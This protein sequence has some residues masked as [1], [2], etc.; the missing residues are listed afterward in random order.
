MPR[1]RKGPAT[2]GPEGTPAQID[3]ELF[4]I[5]KKDN[6]VLR[7]RIIDLEVAKAGGSV[8]ILDND[9]E[10][11]APQ[12]VN[13]SEPDFGPKVMVRIHATWAPPGIR[14]PSTVTLSTGSDR[15]GRPGSRSYRFITDTPILLPEDVI[16]ILMQPEEREFKVLPDSPVYAAAMQGNLDPAHADC[17]RLGFQKVQMRQDGLFYLSYVNNYTVVRDDQSL[18]ESVISL[19]R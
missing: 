7:Q 6:E 4:E 1:G 2:P 19:P 12:A 15:S 18:R 16:K 8:A 3:R 5:L 17:A 9:P 11:A 13:L 14:V 10:L